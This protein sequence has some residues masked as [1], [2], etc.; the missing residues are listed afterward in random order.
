MTVLAFTHEPVD[1]AVAAVV[2]V[3]MT[4]WIWWDHRPHR[5]KGER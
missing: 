4:A 3:A 2:C 1:I 5:D